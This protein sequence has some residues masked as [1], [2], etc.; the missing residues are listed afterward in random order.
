VPGKPEEKGMESVSSKPQLD[1]L[2]GLEM[3]VMGKMV[4]ALAGAALLAAPALAQFG[5]PQG[6]GASGTVQLLERKDVQ[7]EL[8]LEEDDLAKIP[9]AVMDALAK[10][11]KPEQ[12]KRLK[13]LELQRRGNRAFTDAKIQKA[14]KIT[15]EQKE[16]IDT[17]LKDAAK[18][19]Q[20]MFAAA[21]S[22][23]PEGFQEA[24]KKMETMNKE[25]TKKIQDVL[26]ADQK[27]LW[28]A[29]LG[30][31]FKFEQPRFGRGGRG[32]RGQ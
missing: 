22:G 27:K 9:D 2:G 1:S 25:T 18:E 5:P 28:K 16:Q 10:S 7:K 14:L 20:E 31:P 23:G 15:D 12:F 24:R 30:K 32:G 21:R 29:M 6:G 26:T 8:G 17:V 4:L 19:M 11:L 3:R 13:E